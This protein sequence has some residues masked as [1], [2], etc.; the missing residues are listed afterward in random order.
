MKKCPVCKGDPK[1][2]TEKGVCFGHGAYADV[3]HIHCKSCRI[4][5]RMDQLE[6]TMEDLVKKWDSLPRSDIQG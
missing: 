1:F 3:Y 5:L 6:G 2:Y 4:S